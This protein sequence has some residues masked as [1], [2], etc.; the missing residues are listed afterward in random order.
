MG[1]AAPPHPVTVLS[2]SREIGRVERPG[3][4]RLRVELNLS[5]VNLAAISRLEPW[6]GEGRYWTV[7]QQRR[8]AA[9]RDPR[10]TARRRTREVTVAV[11]AVRQSTNELAN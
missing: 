3:N 8:P 4:G 7:N 9:R 1:A 10:R 2:T 6:I 5:S 11:R